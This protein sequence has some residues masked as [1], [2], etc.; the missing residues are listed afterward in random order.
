MTPTSLLP[1]VDE[2]GRPR[3]WVFWCTACSVC[4]EILTNPALGTPVWTLEGDAQIPTV[5][6]PIVTQHA[7]RTC[8]CTLRE[9]W[10]CYEAS[11]THAM[12]GQAVPL[13]LPS[14]LTTD[15]SL[16][17]NASACHLHTEHSPSPPKPFLPA[18]PKENPHE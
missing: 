6:E 3:G 18:V 10:L 7:G 9:G 13:A 15:A 5:R 4:H 16:L 17:T 2:R 14:W 1:S 11:S 12:A 8:V